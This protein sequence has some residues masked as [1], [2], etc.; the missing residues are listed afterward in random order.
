[1]LGCCSDVWQVSSLPAM[2]VLAAQLT[3][4]FEASLLAMGIDSPELP[5]DWLQMLGCYA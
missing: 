4:Q 1:M 2:L 3:S 5:F